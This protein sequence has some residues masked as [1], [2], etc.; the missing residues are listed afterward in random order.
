MAK[1]S[2]KD[3]AE[4]ILKNLEKEIQENNLQPQLA[5]ILAG[6]DPSSKI[7]VKN[8]I[9]T[10]ER[11]GVI[12]G[13]FEFKENELNKCIELLDK[14]NKDSNVHG[15]IIQHPVYPSWDYDNLLEKLNPEKDVD[16]FLPDSPYDGATAL[17]VW[18]MLTAFAIKEGYRQT[19]DFLKGKKI[20]V[21]GQGKTAGGPA[22]KLLKEKGFNPDVVV[23]ETENPNP[24]IKSGDVIISATGVK[25]IINKNNLKNGAYV[26]GVGV[27]KET[28]NGEEKIY[29]DINEDEVSEIAKLYCPTIGGI[30]PLTIVSLLKNVVESSKKARV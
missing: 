5:I 19:E 29:G 17:A 28:D 10:A 7:Y 21:I 2:G 4:V 9:K 6:Q 22:V 15:V 12:A 3:V 24:I 16:G 23:K 8:K 1:V 25:N 27:G 11:I 14:L 20:V 18:E 30:G 26:V 13:L